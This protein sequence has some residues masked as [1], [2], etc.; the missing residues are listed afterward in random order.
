MIAKN[1]AKEKGKGA[2]QNEGNNDPCLPQRQ[3]EEN[4]HME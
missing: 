2:K 3:K 4:I 1:R